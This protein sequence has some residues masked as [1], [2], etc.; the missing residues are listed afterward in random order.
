MGVALIPTLDAVAHHRRMSYFYTT[1]H[2]C[3]KCGSKETE[4]LPRPLWM[5]IVPNIALMRCRICGAQ[6]QARLVEPRKVID[7]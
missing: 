6:F 1:P 2:P 5:K 3:R 4:R 7:I